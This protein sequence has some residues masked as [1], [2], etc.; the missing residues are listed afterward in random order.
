MTIA[1]KINLLFISVALFLALALTGLT[2][3]REYH[4]VLD[5]TV[6]T[7][8]TKVRGRPD[9][10]LALYRRQDEA[11]T[12]WCVTVDGDSL[13]DGT[14]TV[15]DRDTMA[16]ERVPHAELVG[17]VRERTAAWSRTREA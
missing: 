14:V 6:D 2:A 4:L 15:R 1:G 11:G 9:L 12:P 16:Q 8:V 10:Q 5:A 7:L 13:T 17:W 3:W